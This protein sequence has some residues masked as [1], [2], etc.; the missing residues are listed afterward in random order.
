MKFTNRSAEM[1]KGWLIWHS[2]SSYE[3][4]DS[5]LFLQRPDGTTEEIKGDFINAMNGNF[6]KLPE[7]IIF[8]AFDTIADEWDI[9]LYDK[10]NVTNLTK[11][12][13]YNN[14]DPKWSPDGKQIVFK[15]SP[16][17]SDAEEFFYC[18]ALLDMKTKA[19][20][21]LTSDTAEEAMP[22]FSSDGTKI[23]F[24]KYADKIGSIFCL[25]LIT[26][27][28]Q[29]IFSEPGVSAYYP[30]ANDT[31]LYFTKWL[32]AEDHH[33]QLVCFDGNKVIELPFNSEKF[34]CSDVC[35]VNQDFIIYSST[36]DKDGIYDLYF[37]NGTVSESIKNLNTDKNELGADFYVMPV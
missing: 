2:Y 27:M 37:Y 12:S 15:R 24:T 34:D 26:K 6:G 31:F 29:T 22:C 4:Q 17:N 20:T 14:E 28:I 3:A 32:N 13:G 5:R 36:K 25:D 10:G 7:Q 33:D 8:M 21:I 16:R 11:N 1:P 30:I 35:P 19:V 9:F 18:L 23:Y